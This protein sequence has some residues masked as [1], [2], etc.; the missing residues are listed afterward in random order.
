MPPHPSTRR[1]HPRQPRRA[2]RR[3]FDQVGPLDGN[4][5][6]V[7]LELH[8]PVVLGG[9]AIDPQDVQRRATRAAHRLEHVRGPVGHRLQRRAH[10]MFAR[11]PACQP[12]DRTA[13]VRLPMRRTEAGERRDE[14][15]AVVALERS[16]HCLRLAGLADDAQTIAQPLHRRTRDEDAGL[17]RVLRLPAWTAGHRRED[18]LTPAGRRSPVCSNRKAPVP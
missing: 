7:T 5:E 12:D 10:E 14:V 6:H 17:Q 1:R 4:A 2:Q 9:T 13:R 11:S 18:A 16:R 3:G 15:H 8:Q